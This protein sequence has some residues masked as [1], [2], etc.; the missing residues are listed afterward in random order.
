MS[1]AYKCI[2]P[3]IDKGYFNRSAVANIISWS[4]C[5]KNGMNPDYFREFETFVLYSDND[6]G[7]MFARNSDGLY[8]CWTTDM[9]P[10]VLPDHFRMNQKQVL[11]TTLEQNMAKYTKREVKGAQLAKQFR[12]RFGM[13]S[14]GDAFDMIHNGMVQECPLTNH[15]VY[16]ESV[17]WTKY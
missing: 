1:T 12:E 3:G 14:S 7:W 8:S 5:V 11:V 15:D 13:M 6:H 16:R 2:I 4:L 10:V 17:I 9:S